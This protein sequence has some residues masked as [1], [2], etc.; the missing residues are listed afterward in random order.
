[1]QSLQPV[2]FSRFRVS[3]MQPADGRKQRAGWPGISEVHKSI[4]A[5]QQSLHL[6]LPITT[7]Y[8]YYYLLL[9]PITYY[10]L[11]LLLVPTTTTT[12]LITTY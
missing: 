10:Y 9:V 5:Q 12:I 8:Y 2:Y 7:Y 3:C 1:M 6:Q 4:R 11:L